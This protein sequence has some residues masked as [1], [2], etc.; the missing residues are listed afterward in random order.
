MRVGQRFSGGDSA[1]AMPVGVPDSFPVQASKWRMLV[2]S[3]GC[4]TG[5][6]VPAGPQQQQGF[7]WSLAALE[8]WK[9]AAGGLRTEHQA[10]GQHWEDSVRQCARM[11]RIDVG[12]A[13]DAGLERGRLGGKR[14]VMKAN[15]EW[16]QQQ[17]GRP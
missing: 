9:C 12:D 1:S 13:G 16:Q 7:C 3:H 10:P 5:W 8:R 11:N 15:I 17:Y 14:M 6:E 4:A 2:A